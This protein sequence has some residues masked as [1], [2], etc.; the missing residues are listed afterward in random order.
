MFTECTQTL[1]CILMRNDS[2]QPSLFSSSCSELSNIVT[3]N[4]VVPYVLELLSFYVS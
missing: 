1:H 2:K 4:Y 3:F